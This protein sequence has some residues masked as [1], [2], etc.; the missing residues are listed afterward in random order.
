MP[1]AAAS[2]DDG[3]VRA[4]RARLAR[5]IE[6][7]QRAAL[8]RAVRDLDARGGNAALGAW[9]SSVELTASRAGLLLTGDLATATTIVATETRGQGAI[10]VAI[11]L[12]DL[13]AFCASRAHAGMRSRFT[14]T[15]PESV[16]PS[17]LPPAPPPSSSSLQIAP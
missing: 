13:I 1:K 2:T 6:P 10:P 12:G 5:H 15:A 16:H 4:L 17:P 7:D 3:A 9:M 11:R 8:D 14:M